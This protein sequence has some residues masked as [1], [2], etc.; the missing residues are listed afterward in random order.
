MYGETCLELFKAGLEKDFAGLYDM[1]KVFFAP[2]FV[3]ISGLS[4]LYF[5]YSLLPFSLWDIRVLI[6]AAATFDA[7]LSGGTRY[8]FLFLFEFVMKL[9][10][11]TGP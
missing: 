7:S 5:F 9:A 8:C 6:Q 10:G 1:F 11:E 4:N 2:F 3:Y